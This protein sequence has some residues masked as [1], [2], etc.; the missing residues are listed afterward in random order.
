[1]KHRLAIALLAASAAAA[2]GGCGGSSAGSSSGGASATSAS[3]HGTVSVLY[4][5]SLANLMERDLGPAFSRQTGYGYEGFGAGSTELVAQIKSAVREGDVFISASP[6]ADAALEGA[7]NGNHATW[8]VTFAKAPLVIG[9]DPHSRFARRF[10]SEPWYRVITQPGIRVGRTDP[11]LDPKGKLTDKAVEEAAATLHLPSLS[12]A[13]A[14]FE[15]FPEESLVG[16]LEAGQLDAG[17]FY[18]NEARE[19]HLPVVSLAPTQASA[20][21]TVTLLHGAHNEPGAEAFIA[22]LLGSGARTALQEHGLTALAPS[23]SG[24][25]GSV[26]PSLRALAGAG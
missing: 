23:L 14:G 7:A 18:A 13:L 26:P 4:A 9:Y 2:V 22:F 11:K 25:P 12:R 6:T 16:R 17:F 15:V 20:T 10:A 5:G 1:M 19:Q 8:Y 3:A 24:S 21:F